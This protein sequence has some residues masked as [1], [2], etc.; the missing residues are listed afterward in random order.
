MKAIHKI[1]FLAVMA[2]SLPCVAVAVAV[3][4]FEMATA[5]I[6]EGRLEQAVKLLD[7]YIR[8]N[9][10]SYAAYVNRGSALFYM[11]YVFRGVNDWHKAKNLAPLFA[12]GVYTG[13][14]VWQSYPRGNFL[15][16]V[17]SIELYPDH[18]A[19]VNML[20]ATYLDF[21]MNEKALDLFKK[22]SEL[23]ANPLF[24]TDLEWWSYTLNPSEKPRPR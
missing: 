1:C 6:S 16:Y 9:P 15:D 19:T 24:K 11:G 3:T 18:V 14:I 2:V 7:S 13:E 20:G 5:A 8:K 23:T 21:G 4:E 10:K 22:S 17:A 12:Y